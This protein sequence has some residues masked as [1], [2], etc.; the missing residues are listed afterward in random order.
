[1]REERVRKITIAAGIILVIILLAMFVKSVVF[2]GNSR[3]TEGGDGPGI[4][5]T[6]SQG[7]TGDSSQPVYIDAGG[8]RAVSY[9]HLIRVRGTRLALGRLITDGIFIK[10]VQG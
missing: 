4:K 10:E 7:K 5:T 2:S 8:K 3:Q 9:T 1:M 6:G